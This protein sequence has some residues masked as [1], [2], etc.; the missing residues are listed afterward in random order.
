MLQALVEYMSH[1]S[2]YCTGTTLDMS[3][4][5][6]SIDESQTDKA[7]SVPSY[8]MCTLSSLKAVH[9]HAIAGSY[10]CMT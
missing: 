4:W 7:W 2:Y 8:A 3:L 10:A 1:N 6:A 5:C 9:T